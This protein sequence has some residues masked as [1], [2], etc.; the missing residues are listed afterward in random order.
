M[1]RAL[2]A[3]CCPGTFHL[4]IALFGDFPLAVSWLLLLLFCPSVSRLQPEPSELAFFAGFQIL[5]ALHEVDCRH[6]A[7]DCY[8]WLLWS[9][10]SG[11]PG[12]S[13]GRLPS[14]SSHLDRQEYA[15]LQHRRC[16]LMIDVAVILSS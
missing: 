15:E 9:F 13:P 7:R 10:R 5:D 1:L 16:L 8:L 3:A 6:A 12:T 11:T 4:V 14:D 2:V